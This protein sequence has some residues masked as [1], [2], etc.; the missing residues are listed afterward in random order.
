MSDAEVNSVRAAARKLK[1]APFTILA[2]ATAMS[3]ARVRNIDRLLVGSDLANRSLSS[4]REIVG[5]LVTTRPLVLAGLRGFSLESVVAVAKD[6]MASDARYRGVCFEEVLYELGGSDM[7]KVNLFES[8]GH[9][10]ARLELRGVDVELRTLPRTTRHRRALGVFWY[11]TQR[12]IRAEFR[13]RSDMLQE[14]TVANLVDGI[15]WALSARLGDGNR[16]T[17]YGG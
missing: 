16:T 14:Q 10:S 13:W 2:V 3:I 15:H 4:R 12:G 9:E 1:V 7:L 11:A 8:Q 5:H 17:G 6:D